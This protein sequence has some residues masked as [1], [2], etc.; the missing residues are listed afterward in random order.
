[1]TRAW[2]VIGEA[3]W[4]NWWVTAA[5]DGNFDPPKRYLFDLSIIIS[6]Y[7][8]SSSLTHQG[9]GTLVGQQIIALG[10]LTLLADPASGRNHA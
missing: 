9:I 10:G 1:M 4:V 7:G 6:I 3:W 5:W 2:W 8:G